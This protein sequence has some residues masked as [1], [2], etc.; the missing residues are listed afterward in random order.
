M[1]WLAPAIATVGSLANTL[2]QNRSARKEYNEMKRYNSPAQQMKRYQ[3]AGLSP[4]LIYGAANAGNMNAP[5]P[6]QEYGLDTFG[7][8]AQ[9]GIENY[10]AWKQFDVSQKNLWMD[11]WNKNKQNLLLTYSADVKEL[12]SQKRLLEIY[13]DYPDYIEGV[14]REIV[15]TGFR[16]KLNELK[17]AA[18]KA[19]IDRMA[20]NIE[21]MKFK[22]VVD[23]VKARYADEFGMVGGDWTQ[24][25]GLLKS[26]P[27]MFKGARGIK[28]KMPTQGSINQNRKTPGRIYNSRD[29]W[30]NLKKGD[31]DY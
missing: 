31:Y 22:N 25:L 4:Y 11:Y 16:R 2:L 12:E 28:N 27:S 23:R 9:K 13:S 8:G 3:E 26:L 19:A 6:S 14:S 30:D 15:G 21:G 20:V 10:M 17:M 29:F 1:W 7:A 18:S 24:G 5:A